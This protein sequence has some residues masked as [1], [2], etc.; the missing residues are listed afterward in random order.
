MQ[1]SSIQTNKEGSIC[2]ERSSAEVASAVSFMPGAALRI[3][4]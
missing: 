4:K 1:R 3:K 2:I